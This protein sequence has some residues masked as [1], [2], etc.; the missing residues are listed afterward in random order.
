MPEDQIRPEC[1]PVDTDTDGE[2]DFAADFED[3]EGQQ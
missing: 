2:P 3:Q 1:P